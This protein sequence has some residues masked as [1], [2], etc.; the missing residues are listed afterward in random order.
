MTNVLFAKLN[1]KHYSPFFYCLYSNLFFKD[2][3]QYYE[4]IAK[5]FEDKLCLQDVIIGINRDNVI[6]PL[7]KFS[8]INW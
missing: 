3:G 2:V 4:T 8:D 1:R 7:V 6:M 5:D